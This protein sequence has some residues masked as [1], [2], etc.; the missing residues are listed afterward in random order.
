[1]LSLNGSTSGGRAGGSCSP[2]SRGPPSPNPGCLFPSRPQSR[3]GAAEMQARAGGLWR[4]RS[5][6]LPLL[7]L[8]LWGWKP[9][10]ARAQRPPTDTGGAG[11]ASRAPAVRPPPPLRC[12]GSVLAFQRT[13]RIAFPLRLSFLRDFLHRR[14]ERMEESLSIS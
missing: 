8:A 14:R 9:R 6:L 2:A 4:R 5:A 13:G 10:G 12:N 3:S 1:M 7:L 11:G